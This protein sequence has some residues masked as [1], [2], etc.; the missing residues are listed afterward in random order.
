MK[1][2]A[3][4]TM[5][6]CLCLLLTGCT[7]LK[8]MVSRLQFWKASKP[9][10]TLTRAFTDE[11]V[12]R[13]VSN[14]KPGRGNPCSHYL[15]GK[16]YQSAGK[17][18]AAI[19][20]FRKAILADHRFV[21]AYNG[22]GVSYDRVGDSSKAIE[23]YR[24]A[25]SLR[26]ELDYV[27]NNLGYSHLLRGEMDEAITALKKAVELNDNKQYHNNLG[28]A[29]ARKGLFDLA[30]AEF[31]LAGGEARAHYNLAQFCYRK[32]LFDKAAQHYALALAMDPS[33]TK[34]EKGADRSRMLA[35]AVQ[36]P[37]KDT[38]TENNLITSKENKVTGKNLVDARFPVQHGRNRCNTQ[39]AGSVNSNEI[40]L[41][42]LY[43]R[44]FARY[45]Q[46]P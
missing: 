41:T 34:A 14:L 37:V 43:D 4:V 46:R 18:R 32:G 3:A 10:P 28:L 16:Y 27:Y 2:K 23:F 11:D 25:L 36:T 7:S 39:T 45:P 42:F 31:K 20:E 9:G 21:E 13:F 26:P 1:V 15:L 12:K 29:Y 40:K 24:L 30:L 17:H 38:E 35:R 19:E 8:D 22:I 44:L 33:L 6:L 5:G